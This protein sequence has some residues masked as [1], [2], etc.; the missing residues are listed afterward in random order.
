ME[1][2]TASHEENGFGLWACVLKETGEFCGQCGL[3]SQEVEGSKEIEVGYLFV[4][5]FWGRG[6]ATEAARASRD[7]GFGR[8]GLGRLVSLKNPQNTPSRKVAERIGMR[9]EKELEWRGRPTCVYSIARL[10]TG[11][12]E[13]NGGGFAAT[14]SPPKFPRRCRSAVRHG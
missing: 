10:E 3:V 5:R 2:V 1:W 12:R 7:F 6:M 9:L 14:Y 4:R 11:S 8:L 13:T